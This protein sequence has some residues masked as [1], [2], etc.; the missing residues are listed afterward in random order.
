MRILSVIDTLGQGGAERSLVDLARGLRTHDID[1]TI[2]VL[3]TTDHGFEEATQNSDVVTIEHLGS[4]RLNPSR[5][6]REL[7]RLAG[8]DL[9]H[10]TLFE[11]SLIGRLGAVGTDVP[12]LTSLVNVSYDSVRLGDP[13]VTPYKLKGARLIDGW[14]ARHL[15][16]RFHALTETVAASAVVDLG[17]TRHLIEVIP[18]GRAAS[19]F[20][21]VRTDHER[22]LIRAELGIAE[23]AKVL[24]TVGRQEYQKGQRFLIHAMRSVAEKF[25]EAVLLLLG[26]RGQETPYLAK[27]VAELGLDSNV[28]FLGDR[29]DVNRVLRSADVFVFPSLYEGFGGAVIEAMATGLPVVT[30]DLPALVEVLAGTGILVPT[31][32]PEALSA[33]LISVFASDGYTRKMWGKVARERF[34][35]T[36]QL[37]DVVGKMASLIRDTV[38]T[39]K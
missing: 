31:G 19:E 35:A 27:Q 38:A 1:T 21:P 13:R 23:E 7:I 18:R 9:V 10:T 17:I 5:R 11:A 8:I 26:R 15:T 24:I 14:T 4:G 37:D 34:L 16:T 33:A 36:Y 22:S 3:R 20:H 39:G 25:P 28:R 29:R 6:L 12:V 2:A 32:E 30:S